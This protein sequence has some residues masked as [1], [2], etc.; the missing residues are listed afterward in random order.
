MLKEAC[1]YLST[2]GFKLLCTGLADLVSA[3]AARELS[4]K[5]LVKLALPEGLVVRFPAGL[6]PEVLRNIL[7]VYYYLD[8]EM[9]PTFAPRLG[10][11]VVDAGAFIGLYTMRAAKLVGKEG[12]VVAVEPLYSSYSML[13][14][15][16][17]SNQLDNVKLLCAALSSQRGMA[18]LLVPKSPINATLSPNYAKLYG[19]ALEKVR[20]RSIPLDELLIVLKRVDLLKVDVE[21][22]ELE[23]IRGSKLLIPE[24]ASRV[25]IE[26]HI[27]FVKPREVANALEERGYNV[28]VHLPEDA[29]SQ[30]FVYAF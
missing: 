21:G 11:R 2:L 15:N 23:V 9:L 29:P 13:E 19:G 10:W 1:Q 4:A 14:L 22:L 18:D 5:A 16:V 28:V 30:A 3:Y 8:Y 24:R 26:I 6:L 17:R 27:P 25:V 12:F 7:H 20:V